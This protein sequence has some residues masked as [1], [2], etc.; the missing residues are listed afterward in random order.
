MKLNN[1]NGKWDWGVFW[2]HGIIGFIVG[3]L[4]WFSMWFFVYAFNRWKYLINSSI[5]VGVIF[6]L[7]AGFYGDKFWNKLKE[8][9]SP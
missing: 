4:L 9:F 7:L 1:Y 6:F 5:V 3:F 2:L 8:Y